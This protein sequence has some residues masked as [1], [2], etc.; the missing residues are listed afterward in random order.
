[1]QTTYCIL[2][3]RDFV[4][5]KICPL[6][7]LK[8]ACDEV[9]NGDYPYELVHPKCY[10]MYPEYA[11]QT[12]YRYPSCVVVTGRESSPVKRDLVEKWESI[13]VTLVFGTWNPGQ[14]SQDVFYPVKDSDGNIVLTERGQILYRADATQ[15][16]QKSIK[17]WEDAWNF[18]DTAERVIG[19]T[20]HF[21][22]YMMLDQSVKIE[23]GDASAYKYKHEFF[24]YF[25]TYIS[26]NV[27]TPAMSTHEQ[28]K[29]L[30]DN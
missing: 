29:P 9:H 17:G 27:L 13:P 25:F 20:Q 28:I 22:K 1:M 7:K 10:A 18:A 12:D 21:G 2:A 6:V 8:K 23:K 11:D 15:E 4:Q 19:N 3:I 16:F 30:L 5:E 24:P 14:H 26:F